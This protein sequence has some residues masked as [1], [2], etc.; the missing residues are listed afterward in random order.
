[1][2][3]Q[4][5]VADSLI[6][7]NCHICVFEMADQLTEE[8]IEE[9]KEA[10][11]LFSKS[12][13]DP[14]EEELEELRLY[15]EEQRHLSH[16]RR[17]EQE[18]L[19][20]LQCM[21]ARTSSLTGV[22]LTTAEDVHGH[23]NGGLKKQELVVAPLKQFNVH[24]DVVDLAVQATLTQVFVNPT[25]S[26]LEVTY[27]F[28]VL[29]AA[30]V[31][32]LTANLAGRIVKGHVSEKQAAR[33]EYA[34]AKE[35]N[36]TAC[37]LEKVAGDVLRL[38][39]GHLPAGA[40]AVISLEL[41]MQM[42]NEGLRLLSGE[43]SLRL[44]LPAVI[45]SRYPL[46]APPET[47]NSWA[48][49]KLALEEGSAG[50]GS[51]PFCLTLSMV[52]PC[53]VSDARSPTHDMQINFNPNEP[54]KLTAAMSLPRMPDGEIVFSVGLATPL[55][56]RCWIEPRAEG[57]AVL[58]VLYPDE[59][60]LQHLWP[61]TAGTAAVPEP[62]TEF[63]FVLDRSGSMSGG[64]IRKAADAL[65]LFLRSLPP[66][67]CFDIIGFGST[68]QSLFGSSMSY[69]A[70][71]LQR[72]SD[73]AKSVK[74]DLGGTELLAPLQAIYNRAIPHGH[75]RRIVVLTDG[76]VSNTGRVL[77]LV[78]DHAALASVFTVGIGSSVSHHLV[79]GMA[80]A[81]G[82][83]AEFVAGDERLEAKVMRQLRR[84]L[85]SKP[86]PMLT[87]VEWP[88]MSVQEVAPHAL[89][90]SGIAGQLGIRCTGDRVLIGALVSSV[91]AAVGDS[92]RLHF[93]GPQGQ[94]SVLD[95]PLLQLAPG[96]LLHAM[97]GRVLIDDALEQCQLSA[98]PHEKD[99]TMKRVISLATQM[100]LVTKHTSFIAV[101]DVSAVP[102]RELEASA[103]KWTSSVPPPVRR[104]PP[105]QFGDCT[106]CTKEL[107]T[108]MRS[109]GQNPTAAELQDMI[110]EV[111]ADG[112]GTIDFPEFLSLQA[113]KMKDTDTEEELIEAFRVFDTD[114]SG[115]IDAAALRHVM[116]NLGEKITDEEVEEMLNEAEAYSRTASAPA[117]T[118]ASR[119]PLQA[120]CAPPSRAAVTDTD[121]LQAV[122][123][124]QSFDGSWELTEDLTRAIGFGVSLH[125]LAP[126]AGISSTAWATA[127]SV[128]FLEVIL[129]SMAEEWEFVASKARAWLTREMLTSQ[130]SQ[131]ILSKACEKM[132]GLQAED[133]KKSEAERLK[134]VQEEE[135]RQAQIEMM[136]PLAQN[137]EAPDAMQN[138]SKQ[139]S[140]P[141]MIAYEDFVRMM[142]AK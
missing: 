63:L 130:G 111:D 26:P 60:M 5:L 42:Q 138:T 85:K 72:A 13:R 92:L 17:L 36:K 48:D 2:C 40:E 104:R 141:R 108:V 75:V 3:F 97:V 51:A 124:L 93:Q 80:E 54:T 46:T 128:V 53:L 70:E 39:I 16:L 132:K 29:P 74:A 65:Q 50:S 121:K 79:E 98:K 64:Q 56:S 15:E 112:N 34:A 133:A 32:G 68:W 73:H 21:L 87:S 116:T 6:Y 52:M 126:E 100:Q 12:G 67:C 83:S 35:E 88:G 19:Q 45:G 99:V 120:A 114:G 122:V 61:E 76:A 66:D 109:L 69:G 71:T 1:L 57:A 135:A 113:R 102:G 8:Q 101:D 142:M 129:P 115:L 81:G 11:I 41:A 77:A 62:P 117:P 27:T 91:D 28:P 84:A 4:R 24:L 106:I 23:E 110:N 125:D 38:K 136:K 118:P 131:S 14:T 119:V 43:G 89:A 127:L 33:A 107:G 82:G 90:H 105:I 9:F 139:S 20:R 78:R 30:T 10:F 137:V 95:V 59:T 86:A 31:C 96:R 7:L 37:L 94:Q 47:A 123:L 140:G 49:E 22:A 25:S 18:E 58:A 44:A 134:L 103:N 55:D